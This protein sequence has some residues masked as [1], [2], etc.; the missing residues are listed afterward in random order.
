MTHHKYIYIVLT[1][2]GTLLN[3][4]IRLYTGDLLN[5]ASLS[6]D[7]GLQHVYSFGRKDQRNPWLGGFVRENMRGDLMRRAQCAVY[8]IRVTARQYDHLKSI[9]RAF[10]QNEHQYS[11]NLLGLIGVACGI[12][13]KRK[14]KFFCSEFVAHVLSRA[15]IEAVDKPTGLVRPCDFAKSPA[16]KPV[17]EGP[18]L[19]YLESGRSVECVS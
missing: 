18:V 11:F 4:L 3:R 1:D 13:L 6:L 8:Q 2:T 14:H 12:P 17:Y 9:I 19:D 7:A 5:H 15:G 10:E 16:L